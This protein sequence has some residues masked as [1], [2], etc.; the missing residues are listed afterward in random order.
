MDEIT[1]AIA[2]ALAGG[3]GAGLKSVASSSV[4]DLYAQLKKVVASRVGGRDEAVTQV[5][6]AEVPAPVAI[7]RALAPHAHAL[8]G[9]D[10]R[11]LVLSLLRALA[12]ED[13]LP[14]SSTYRASIRGAMADL[15][16]RVEELTAEQY[17]IISILRAE[18]QVLISGAAGSGKTLVAAEK[19][20]RLAD[21]GLSVLFLCHNPLLA[22][23]V[24]RLVVGTR[25]EVLDFTGW[26]RAVLGTDGENRDGWSE[27]HEPTESEVLSA[28]DALSHLHPY[29][30]II[31]DEA[32]DFR[33]EWWLLVDAAIAGSAHRILYIFY[34]NAQTLLKRDERFPIRGPLLDLTRN[35]RNSGPVLQVMSALQPGLPAS[36]PVLAR[37]GGV[38]CL[39][40][41]PG[42]EAELLEQAL[43]YCSRAGVDEVVFLTAQQLTDAQI[44]AFEVGQGERWQLLVEREVNSLHQS[45]PDQRTDGFHPWW[46]STDFSDEQTPTPKDLHQLTRLV[47]RI[48]EAFKTSGNRQ[49]LTPLLDLQ[50]QLKQSGSVRKP[51]VI[52][53]GAPQSVT[54]EVAAYSIAEFKGLE[55]DGVIF[56]DRGPQA[57]TRAELYVAASRARSHLVLIMRNETFRRYNVV[58]ALGRRTSSSC[59]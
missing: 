29:D 44:M 18:P 21:S 4:T 59:D 8:A 6:D 49:A 41:Q 55:S 9:E 34:D 15:G 19:A 14:E 3:A 50:E 57:L 25:V 53:H 30:A 43:A 22:Q 23:H 1:T 46:A 47:A 51:R 42:A 11:E 36:D 35:C 20:A 33:E 5:V 31:V 26:V 17:R 28:L 13:L 32:Q 58:D 16:R 40:W 27:Y 39:R 38:L 7:E 45:H 48:Q 54:G 56:W 24:Q 37:L 52:A 12:D 2:V 10:V